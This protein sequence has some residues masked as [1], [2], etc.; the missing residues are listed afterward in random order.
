MDGHGPYTSTGHVLPVDLRLGV[1][2][3]FIFESRLFKMLTAVYESE[4][5]IRRDCASG[6][7]STKS[8]TDSFGLAVE[9]ELHYYRWV[10]G[11]FGGITSVIKELFDLPKVTK[12]ECYLE[13]DVGL[14][15][16]SNISY[17]KK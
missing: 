2:R 6:L 15:N 4:V 16:Q 8:P 7:L 1:R 12:G 11:R 14:E 9:L 13:H 5:A 10:P 17:Q 3:R